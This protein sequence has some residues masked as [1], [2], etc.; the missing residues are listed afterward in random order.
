MSRTIPLLLLASLHACTTPADVSKPLSAVSE[1]NAKTAI[2]DTDNGFTVEVAYSRYQFVPETNALLVACRSI[3]TA[4]AYEEA[5]RRGREIEPLNEQEIRVSAGRNIL[6]AR[7][8][9]KA[10]AEARWK[11]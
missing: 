9:C 5:K 6:S 10:F 11:H 1:P 8:A 7:T 3:L 2:N 4:K